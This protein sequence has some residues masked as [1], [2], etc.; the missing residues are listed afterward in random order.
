MI[1]KGMNI[2]PICFESFA[3]LT[4]SLISVQNYKAYM[5][6]NRSGLWSFF[7]L[8]NHRNKNHILP[9]QHTSQP[10]SWTEYPGHGK[11]LDYWFGVFLGLVLCYHHYY[12]G[13]IG[14]ASFLVIVTAARGLL[15]GYLEKSKEDNW[16][17]VVLKW[18]YYWFVF[19]DWQYT[20]TGNVQ[21]IKLQL[22]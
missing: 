20:T 4:L 15:I 10:I 16:P 14:T 12:P 8:K 11:L 1:P 9:S 7:I 17:W 2:M 21:E 3:Q 18:C 22:Y 13:I 19:T 6:Y 5:L